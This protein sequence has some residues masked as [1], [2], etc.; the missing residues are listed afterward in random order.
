[1]TE[2]L[3]YREYAIKTKKWMI[4]IGAQ[5]E[6]GTDISG[7][8]PKHITVTEW[9]IQFELPIEK[10]TGNPTRWSQEQW[11]HVKLMMIQMGIPIAIHEF[12]GHY[13]GEDGDE[14]S[15]AVFNLNQAMARLEKVN[16]HLEAMRL[17]GNWKDCHDKMAGRMIPKKLKRLLDT[18]PGVVPERYGGVPSKEL[19]L[20]MSS[21]DKK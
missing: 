2:E 17:G 6:R 20:L 9:A 18:T 10:E 4:D 1:M 19:A 12:R 7:E 13:I 14:I 16:I 11:Q 8:I 21:K 3:N 15:N 5:W